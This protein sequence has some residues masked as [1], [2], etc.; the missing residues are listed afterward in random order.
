MHRTRRRNRTLQPLRKGRQ[1]FSLPVRSA[2]IPPSAD[3]L[4]VL[5]L[6]RFRLSRTLKPF[7]KLPVQAWKIFVKTTVFVKDMNDFAKV[8]KLL[9]R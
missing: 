2:L 4:K 6:K 9:R 1:R 7:S 3:L 5:R 8:N